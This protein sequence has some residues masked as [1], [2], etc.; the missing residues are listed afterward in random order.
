MPGPVQRWPGPE[1]HA[2][3]QGFESTKLHNIFRTLVSAASDKPSDNCS[4]APAPRLAVGDFMPGQ[5]PCDRRPAR[6]RT[7]RRGG[8]LV[9]RR[10]TIRL[11]HLRHS[12]QGCPVAAPHG[13]DLRRS[14]ASAAMRSGCTGSSFYSERSPPDCG[15]P[16]VVHRRMRRSVRTR[17]L[18]GRTDPGRARTS[19]PWR[20]R[21]YTSCG[22]MCNA[23]REA[24]SASERGKLLG[25]LAKAVQ[26]AASHEE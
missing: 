5:Q 24:V 6:R 21:P 2:R 22:H 11:R 1:W 9:Q 10:Q 23:K 8:R 18:R 14:S 12:P 26:L 3:G 20:S 19:P 13:Q 16:A 4:P 25:K 7:A 15:D 17:L